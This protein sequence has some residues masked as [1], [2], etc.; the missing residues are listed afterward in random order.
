MFR[1]Q[2][3]IMRFFLT[4]N[5]VS[6]WWAAGGQLLMQNIEQQLILWDVPS[7]VWVKWNR[8]CNIRNVPSI[9]FS[10]MVEMSLLVFTFASIWCVCAFH[11]I[12]AKCELYNELKLIYT[13]EKNLL[14]SLPVP[15]RKD[16]KCY[17]TYFLE[18]SVLET[19][20]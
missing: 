5:K 1:S 11:E 4:S 8:L 13:V 17:H 2:M 7:E 20:H 9:S 18:S 12:T 15:I 14:M 10:C 3:F 19:F 6:S 16:W